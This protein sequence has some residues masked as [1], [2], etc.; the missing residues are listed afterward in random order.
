MERTSL[1]ESLR[2]VEAE[3]AAGQPDQ[4]LAHAQELQAWYPRALPIQRVLG[5][6][7]LAQRKPREALG[8]LDR[9]LAGDPEDA[10]ACC[11]RAIATISL[12][13]IIG[14]LTYACILCAQ[15]MPQ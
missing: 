1:S 12:L 13:P 10:R 15:T 8:A 14:R 7:Y 11:A 6:I 5:E 4:A 9:V 2:K 3:I